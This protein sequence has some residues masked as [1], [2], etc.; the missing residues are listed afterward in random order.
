MHESARAHT[1]RILRSEV[2]VRWRNDRPL[3]QRP[4]D[5]EAATVT[6]SGPRTT[7]ETGDSLGGEDADAGM[8]HLAGGP[9]RRNPR[10]PYGPCLRCPPSS[11]QRVT[12]SNGFDA[13]MESSLRRTNA[14]PTPVRRPNERH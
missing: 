9:R 6:D 4:P 8:G 12:R 5:V 11:E 13:A 1:G 2:E 10:A 7:A 3:P 14:S